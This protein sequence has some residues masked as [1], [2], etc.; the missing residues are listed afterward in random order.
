MF[1]LPENTA[2]AALLG[3]GYL[4]RPL[5]VALYES[6]WTVRALKCQLTSDDI[7]LP[8]TLDTADLNTPDVFRQPFWQHWQHADTWVCLLPPSAVADY[9]GCLKS[10]LQLAQTFGVKHLVFTSS[11]AVYGNR[12]GIC[13]EHTP[14]DSTNPRAQRLYAAEQLLLSSDIPHIDILRLGG[15]YSGSRNPLTAL[16]QR[17]I[18]PDADAPANM[19]HQDRAVAALR[20]AVCTPN[21]R[22]I[23]NLVEMPQPTKRVFYMA[24]ARKLGLPVPHFSDSITEGKTVVTAYDDFA[25]LISVAAAVPHPNQ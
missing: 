2:S 24:E 16:L 23:R 3:F 19:L 13:N 10:W 20:R 4:G 11:T 7:N 1:G 22:R 6:G 8:I 18:V 25:D 12:T 15:L 14:S 21:G 9:T 5:A 17:G